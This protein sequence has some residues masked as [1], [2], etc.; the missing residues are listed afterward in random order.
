MIILLHTELAARELESKL[1]LAVVAA[2][3]GHFA[4][5]SDRPTLKRAL[6]LA[7][8]LRSNVRGLFRS[9]LFPGSIF[10]TKSVTPGVSKLDLHAR[11]NDKGVF[12]TSQDEE[13]GL[14]NYGYERFAMQRFSSKS[15]GQLAALFTWGPE[16]Y[17]FLRE[18][19]PEHADK[20]HAT[21][22][23]RAD[24][25]SPVGKSFVAKPRS[26]PNRPFLLVS[27][28]MGLPRVPFKDDLMRLKNAD[29]F[30][31]DPQ[32]LKSRLYRQADRHRLL[33]EFVDAI[34]SLSLASDGYDIVLR[35]HPKD[36]LP[37]WSMLLADLPNVHVV[38]EG[39]ITQWVHHAFAVMHNG[40]TTALEAEIA[41]VPVITY[42]PFESPYGSLSNDLGKRVK[43]QGELKETVDGF[44]QHSINSVGEKPKA[45]S[46]AVSQ[47]VM[48]RP[49]ELA[50]ER[51][52][53][54]WEGVALDR[55]RRSFPW[56]RF[57]LLGLSVRRYNSGRLGFFG[58]L[59]SMISPPIRP[60]SFDK[61]PPQ[62]LDDVRQTVE[63][64]ANAYGVA[65]RV[66]VRRMHS[67]CFVV[68]PKS[69]ENPAMS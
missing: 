60:K 13:A 39:S 6:G 59:K 48:V 40:C 37:T 8:F 19:Y 47:K 50:A 4:V 44:F 69:Q 24:L 20:I 7:G 33:Y 49:D 18:A 68:A 58:L 51:I 35:P 9:N 55:G 3:R 62:D 32:M 61:F 53:R 43:S 11:L 25:W 57:W 10:H 54:I 12:V 22:S 36:D 21:G 16:D 52:V 67:R 38:Q 5:V 41:G 15:I 31:R 28:N 66:S 14:E 42:V 27:S 34:R 30:T 45:V 63:R 17:D 29:Y 56:V 64:F 2:S 26:I 65:G 46:L 23:P 1:L